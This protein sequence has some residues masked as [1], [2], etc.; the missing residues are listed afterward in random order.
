MNFPSSFKSLQRSRFLQGFTQLEILVIVFII[1]IMAAIATPSF[2]GMLETANMKQATL[3]IRT[4]LQE[5]QRQSI[6]Q[7]QA[8]DTRILIQ[9]NA[10]Q[11]STIQGNCLTTGDRQLPHGIG[12]ATNVVI[13]PSSSGSTGAGPSSQFLASLE[14]HRATLGGLPCDSSIDSQCN[15]TDSSLENVDEDGTDQNRLS[16]GRSDKKVKVGFTS[17]GGANFEIAT[18]SDNHRIEGQNAKFISFRPNKLDGE[19]TCVVISR[20]LGLT[21]LGVYEGSFDPVEITESGKCQVAS[22]AEQ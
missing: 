19:K 14:V 15:P 6:R 20:S 21:R 1:G 16:P 17:L 7:N 4:A 22:W 13:D 9:A 10:D 8:C 2:A 18:P 11:G 12:L 5:T 3:E